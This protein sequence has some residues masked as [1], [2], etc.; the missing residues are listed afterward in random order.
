L[1]IQDNEAPSQGPNAVRPYS[2]VPWPSRLQSL[3]D[4]LHGEAQF[5]F[6]P[7]RTD[8]DLYQKGDDKYAL[9]DRIAAEMYAVARPDS[10]SRID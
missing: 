4:R 5:T 6:I 10:K 3:L 1:G 2:H 8:F 9:F 7:R